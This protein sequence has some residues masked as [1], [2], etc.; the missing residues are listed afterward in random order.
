MQ[1]GLCALVVI[2]AA[3]RWTVNAT[4][5]AGVEAGIEATSMLQPLLSMATVLFDAVA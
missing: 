4:I 1:A 5:S 2:L 3:R